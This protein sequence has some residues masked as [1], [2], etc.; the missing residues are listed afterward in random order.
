MVLKKSEVSKSVHAPITYWAVP[1][2]WLITLVAILIAPWLGVAAFW[3][4]PASQTHAGVAD[5]APVKASHAGKWGDLTLV[6]I[7]ISPPTELLL[8]DWGLTRRPIWYFPGASVDMV[9][10]MLQSV[11]VSAADVAHLQADVRPDPRNSGVVLAPDPAWV[12]TLTRETRASIYHI[13]A[14]SELNV[15]QTQAFRYPG[16]DLEAW[17]GSSQISPH[18]RQLIEPLI[19]RDG[20]YMLFSD[21]ELIRTEIG[22]DEEMRRLSK[23]L[24]RHPTVIARLSVGRSANLDALVEYWGRGGRRTEIRP[25]LESVEGGGVDKFIDIIH[26]LPPFAQS[27][28]YCFP[29]L[30]VADLSKSTVVNCLWTSLNFFSPKP[31]DRFLDTAVALKTLKEDY[32]IVETN[33]ELGDI[34]LF[35]DEEGRVFHSVVY[36]ADDLVF[37]KNGISAMAPWTLMSLNDVKG[38]YRWR[39]ENPRL[40]VHRRKDF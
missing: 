23:A 25:L 7:V 9:V 30:S 2:P 12:R 6:P 5:A 27:H 35:L 26:L 39:S 22:G 28:L 34:G 4:R 14:K 15:N 10:Q 3:L 38:Y 33:F 19:Y 31:D 1:R 13:L 21:I 40:I 18:T 37:S 36:I 32:F 17:F 8:T 11:G 24:F 20:D 16:R 29:R